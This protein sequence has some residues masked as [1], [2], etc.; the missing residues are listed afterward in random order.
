M[1]RPGWRGAA[2]RLE[3]EVFGECYRALTH[4][5]FSDDR[6]RPAAVGVFDDTQWTQWSVSAW[7]WQD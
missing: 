5:P 1:T 4:A 7:E 2:V 6:S 3:L